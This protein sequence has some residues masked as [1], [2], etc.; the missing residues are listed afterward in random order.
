LLIFVVVEW[1]AWKVHEKSIDFDRD[2]KLSKQIGSCVLG[3]ICYMDANTVKKYNN[4]P[5]THH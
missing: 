4:I 2:C 5:S 3:D 1:L